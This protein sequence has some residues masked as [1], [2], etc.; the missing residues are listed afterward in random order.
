M[1]DAEF[2]QCNDLLEQVLSENDS[3]ERQFARPAAELEASLEHVAGTLKA[4]EREMNLTSGSDAQVL[5]QTQLQLEQFQSRLSNKLKDHNQAL[6]KNNQQVIDVQVNF[7]K[8][9]LSGVKVTKS[10]YS[11]FCPNKDSLPLCGIFK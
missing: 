11:H 2:L 7:R 3:H 8:A 4:L 1:T 6:E 9:C 5:R 10:V